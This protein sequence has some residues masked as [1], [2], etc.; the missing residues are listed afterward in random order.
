M[1]KPDSIIGRDLEWQVLERFLGSGGDGALRIGIVSGRRRAGKTHLLAAAAGAVGGLYHACVQEEGDLAARARFATAVSAHGGITGG[2]A[3]DWESLLVTALDVAARTAPAGRAPLLVIDEFPYAMAKAPQLP[4]I[5]Q[6]LFDRAQRG[7]GP[8]G[9]V[10]LCGSA[11]SV[12]RELLSGTR[13]LR[14]R[15]MVDL[16]LGP[17]DY[18]Q[19]ADLWGIADPETNLKVHACVGGYPGYRQLI[20]RTPQ[21]PAE[22]EQW[23][24]DTLLSKGLG[25]FTTAEVDYLLREDPRISDRSAYYDVLGAISRGSTSLA[26]IGAETGRSKDAVRPLLRTLE[27]TGYVARRADLVRGRSSI[28]VRDPVIR[29][30]RLITA[31]RLGQLDLGRSEQVW[32]AMRDTFRSQILGPHFEELAREWVHRFAPEDLGRPEGFGEVGTANVHDNAGRAKYEVDV[33]ALQGKA[34][35]FIGE[36]KAT[37]QRQGTGALERL[38]DIAGMLT[39]MGYRTEHAVFGVF[40]LTGFTSELGAAADRD[41]RVALLDLDRLYGVRR[42]PDPQDRP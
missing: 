13:P 28:S 32:G 34:V 25:V 35:T 9:R 2:A 11:L 3:A 22:F 10:I 26:K 40:S 14:G 8:G 23:V 42:R 24:P 33:L 36:A 17:L 7:E 6:L 41:P 19:T 39:G 29:F 18:R 31:P 30:D 15:A 38:R 4:G 12:M 37:G 5:L 16:Q 21:S 27:S 1:D 20:D